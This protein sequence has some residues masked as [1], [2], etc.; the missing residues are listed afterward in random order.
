MKT[1]PPL[2]GG[3]SLK[4]PS[5]RGVPPSLSVLGTGLDQDKNHEKGTPWDG[6]SAQRQSWGVP[7]GSEPAFTFKISQ[8]RFGY[9]QEPIGSCYQ[10]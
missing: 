3:A 4:K 7:P 10:S 5:L 1:V 6:D 2:S 9:Q 8:E